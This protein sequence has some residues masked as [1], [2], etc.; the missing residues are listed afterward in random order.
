[1]QIVLPGKILVIGTAYR[2]AYHSNKFWK[3][4][5]DSIND[6]FELSNYVIL[7][8]D[9]NV[10]ILTMSPNHVLAD[11][12][13]SFYFT[14]VINE[15]TR[16]GPTRS[17]LLDPIL[18]SESLSCSESS[19]ISTENSYTDHEGC[20]AY[21][22]VQSFTTPVYKRKIWLYKRGDYV[23]FNRLIEGFVWNSLFETCDSVDLASERFTQVF[24]GFAGKEIPHKE[25][26][27]RPNYKVWFNSDLRKNMRLRDRLR[28][29]A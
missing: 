8:N 17:S 11:I 23:L 28:E 24:L 4:F 15:P 29:I 14:S 25:V 13:D 16:I 6:A 20:V 10:D 18:V 1:M 5:R 2:S 21:F 22:N 27:L 12:I 7:T 9:P 26:T 19:V 3:T